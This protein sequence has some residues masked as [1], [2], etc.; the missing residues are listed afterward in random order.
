MKYFEMMKYMKMNVVMK[1]IKSW[2]PRNPLGCSLK[3]INVNIFYD[4]NDGKMDEVDETDDETGI[5]RIPVIIVFSPPK[6]NMQNLSIRSIPFLKKS[7]AGFQ[8]RQHVFP[9]DVEAS[10]VNHSSPTPR[11]C[12]ANRVV[13]LHRRG[14]KTWVWLVF[15]RESGGG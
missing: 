7:N 14:Q 13:P 6:K 5:P 3:K 2:N 11:I 8:R 1:M 12:A 9:Q 10:T 4:K 15:F